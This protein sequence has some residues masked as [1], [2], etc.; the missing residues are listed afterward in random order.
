MNLTD[1]IYNFISN[2]IPE[3]DR[4]PDRISI[5]FPTECIWDVDNSEDIVIVADWRVDAPD[6]WVM[7]KK[8][9]KKYIYVKES[10]NQELYRRLNNLLI[11]QYDNIS[12]SEDYTELSGLSLMPTPD[13]SNTNNEL[14]PEWSGDLVGDMYSMMMCSHYHNPTETDSEI[15]NRV[16]NHIQEIG[17][18]SISNDRIQNIKLYFSDFHYNQLEGVRYNILSE[19][20]HLYYNNVETLDEYLSKKSDD[21][22]EMQRL[23]DKDSHKV[24]IPFNREDAEMDRPTIPDNVTDISESYMNE[25]MDTVISYSDDCILEGESIVFDGEN[26]ETNFWIRQNI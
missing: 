8:D 21:E 5:T 26:I 3:K 22:E 19:N 9:D 6:D 14:I 24:L 18:E 17:G 13:Y 10:N 11:S 12:I 15:L 1:N 25:R 4:N 7:D 16:R 2:Q 20:P 23:R